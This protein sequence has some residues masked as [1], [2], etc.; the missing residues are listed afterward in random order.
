MFARAAW[1]RLFSAAAIVERVWGPSVGVTDRAVDVH[2]GRLRKTWSSQ[3]K[4]RDPI[5]KG[6]R[7]AGYSF[8][9]TFGNQRTKRSWAVFKMAA[10]IAHKGLSDPRATDF[11][12][13]KAL[14]ST[15]G[16]GGIA[17]G[18]VYGFAL[19][20]ALWATFRLLPGLLPVPWTG[21]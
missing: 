10:G 6:V 12:C 15:L 9:E 18:I 1:G 5:V 8:D 2:I 4:R 17:S 19:A 13:G 16:T 11:D 14:I 21:G 7:G 20:L 3:I